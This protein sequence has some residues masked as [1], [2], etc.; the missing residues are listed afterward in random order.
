MQSS[1]AFSEQEGGTSSSSTSFPLGG[2]MQSGGASAS[3]FSSGGPPGPPVLAATG[4]VSSLSVLYI[5]AGEQRRSGVKQCLEGLQV[6]WG[7]KLTMKEVDLLRGKDQDVCQGTFRQG[8]MSELRSGKYDLL[9]ITSPCHT[10]SRARSSGGGR[11]GPRPVD[12]ANYPWGFPWLGGTRG[13]H[14][15]WQ[16]LWF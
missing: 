15:S 14:V 4:E 6:R 2:E 9:I 1:R 8:L 16:T 12:S 11:P 3:S 13:K 5:F 10:H 7:Y